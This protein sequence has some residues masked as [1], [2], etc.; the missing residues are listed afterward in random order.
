MTSLIGTMNSK[1]ASKRK[2]R[3]NKVPKANPDKMG[4]LG[5]NHSIFHCR[6]NQK[7]PPPTASSIPT[8]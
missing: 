2:P 5:R 1:L 7:N 4:Y 6:K 8:E 3:R